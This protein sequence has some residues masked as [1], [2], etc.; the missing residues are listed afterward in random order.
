MKPKKKH[1]VYLVHWPEIG[2][3]KAGC[4]S[5][6]RWTA[7]I[8]RGAEVV[9]LVEFDDVADAYAFESVVHAGLAVHGL[10]FQNAAAAEPYLGSEG[11]GW[12][13]CYRVP[14]GMTPMEV[15]CSTEWV[16]A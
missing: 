1:V 5:R 10:G 7:F 13:E 9:D 14:E 2:V 11:G 15:L 4:T 16:P 12:C 6:R 3:M 8:A